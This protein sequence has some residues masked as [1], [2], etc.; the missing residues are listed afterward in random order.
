MNYND[1]GGSRKRARKD[2]CFYRAPGFVRLWRVNIFDRYIFR[3]LLI[4]SLIIA[5][6]LLGVVFLTQSLRFLELVIESGATSAT[7]WLL[8][9][10]ALPRFF[11]I[12]I[13]LSLAAAILFVYNRMTSDSELI[14]IRAVGFDSAMLARPAMLLS[15][16]AMVFLLFN[17]LWLAPRAISGMQEMRQTVKA[18]IS[19]SLFREGVFNQMGQGLTVYIRERAKDG[20]LLGVLIHDGRDAEAPPSTVIAKSGTLILSP[21]GYQVLVYDGSRQEYNSES[22]TLKRLNFNRYSIELPES[23]PVRQRWREPEERTVFEL[24]NP[25]MSV[26]RDVES[27]RDFKVELHRRIVGPFFAVVFCLMACTAL[28]VGSIERRGQALRIL[29]ASITII[30]LQ[31][32]FI[33]VYNWA[34][35]SD[36]GLVLMWVL[37]IIPFMACL[38]VLSDFKRF[39]VSNKKAVIIA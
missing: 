8:A 9:A 22:K 24:I 17:N 33:A 16:F 31:G 4:A 14:V 27:L 15:I 34:R 13:P 11:E 39:Y 29:M 3:N 32:I 28:L 26:P 5:A 21:E 10:L 37:A 20:T 2:S 36:V 19:T 7:F 30:F 35:Q 18:Q 25:D 12:V 23:D 6:T 1:C 38:F